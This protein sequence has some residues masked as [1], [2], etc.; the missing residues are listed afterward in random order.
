MRLSALFD[1]VPSSRDIKSHPSHCTILNFYVL[2]YMSMVNCALGG[3]GYTGV[4]RTLALTW[5][6]GY[7]ESSTSFNLYQ[8]YNL[9]LS[10]I[11][12]AWV[13]H[14]HHHLYISYH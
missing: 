7:L 2:D 5:R 13:P 6:F 4:L 12:K 8:V 1:R 9:T 11:Q 14:L 10:L 3:S